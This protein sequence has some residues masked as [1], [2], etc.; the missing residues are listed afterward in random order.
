MERLDKLQHQS[1]GP[2]LQRLVKSFRQAGPN[3]I[4]IALAGCVL[5][6]AAGR[7]NMK[8]EH[9]ASR[10]WLAVSIFFFELILLP[11]LF[12][13]LLPRINQLYSCFPFC[14]CEGGARRMGERKDKAGQGERRG[15]VE[16]GRC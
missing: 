7:L 13:A 16:V 15:A 10:E 4:N 5:A 11:A 14:M 9:Q 6:V 3:A 8:Y 2:F 1:R 12:V